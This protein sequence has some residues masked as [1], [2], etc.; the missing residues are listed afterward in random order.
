MKSIS[1]AFIKGSTTVVLA[2]MLMGNQS[3]KEE[4]K[5]RE[6]RRR[7][8]MGQVKA[9][10][11]ALPQG[12]SFNFAYVANAQMYDILSKTSAF[13]TATVDPAQAFDPSGLS[14]DEAEVFNQCGEEE[15]THDVNGKIISQKST[16]SQK[17]ACMIDMP[18]GVVSG[19]ILDFTLTSKGGV[20]LKLAGVPVLPG[21]KF[22]FKRSE[23]S[24]TMKVMHPLQEGGI[25]AGDRKVIA[26][27]STQSFAN[28]FGASL[29]LNFS[30]FEIGPS[31][32]YNSPLRKVT[33]AGLTAGINNLKDSWNK[34][35][36]WYAMVLRN[37]DKYIYINAGNASD[38]GLV[39]GDILRIQNVD[40]RWQGEVCKSTMMGSADYI[41]GAVAYAK[42]VSVGDN[43]S[44]AVIIENDPKYP[45][46]GEQIIKPGARVYAEKL[47]V[48]EPAKK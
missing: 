3:C 45:Y 12:G 8:Q 6:L 1:K 33:E 25:Q 18:Q 40:Y 11:I 7:V 34:S 32:Y 48:P 2:G 14:Q 10:P 28:D 19:N 44:A 27:T 38:A 17:A 21:A 37:C 20:T 9:P 46:S 5:V 23:L 13:S 41:G 31:Y 22:D 15:T 42:V 26:T 43:M 47:F 24:L 35:E 36:P 39:N 30:G 16:I 4:T 29:Q